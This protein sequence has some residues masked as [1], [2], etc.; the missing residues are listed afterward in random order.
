MNTIKNLG[1]SIIHAIF[2]AKMRSLRKGSSIF[3]FI[4]WFSRQSLS[5]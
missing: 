4:E 5:T 2:Q 1:S 3:D